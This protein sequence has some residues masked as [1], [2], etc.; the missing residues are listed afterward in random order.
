M[1]TYWAE[2][3]ISG[4]QQ[5]CLP[6]FFALAPPFPLVLALFPALFPG[7]PKMAFLMETTSESLFCD[8]REDPDLPPLDWDP[9]LDPDPQIL[10]SAVPDR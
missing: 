7:G 4:M 3:R 5:R 6:H 8:P 2:F 10:A 9:D 1:S